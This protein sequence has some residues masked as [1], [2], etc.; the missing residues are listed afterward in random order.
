MK[1]E[2]KGNH[3]REEEHHQKDDDDDER[4]EEEEEEEDG[5]W[6]E[7][8]LNEIRG[9]SEEELNACVKVLRNVAPA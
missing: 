3:H 5:V 1:K 9:F 4:K 7:E 8:K 6:F 2:K